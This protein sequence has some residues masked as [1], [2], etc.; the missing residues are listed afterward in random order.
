[1]HRLLVR[2]AATIVTAIVVPVGAGVDAGDPVELPEA[3]AAVAPAAATASPVGMAPAAAEVSVERVTVGL[4]PT[5]AVRNA[6]VDERLRVDE[7]LARFRRSGLRLPDVEIVF[8]D[9]PV[10]CSGHDGRFQRQFTPWRLLVCSE[11]EYVVTHE[12]A[13]AWEAA[14][15]GAAARQA[16]VESRGL[17][18]WDSAELSWRERGVEDVAIVMQQNLMA[19]WVDL[20]SPR[21]MERTD[22][23]EELT[24]R[25]SPAL[26]PL[27]TAVR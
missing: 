1:M 4:T 8:H 23:F 2:T 24:G 19:G 16:Y 9:D 27:V 6:D 12:L 10:E 11:A 7:A 26:P 3:P 17:A 25:R 20:A 14:N 13:H 15:L 5:V 18:G 22:A 21:W